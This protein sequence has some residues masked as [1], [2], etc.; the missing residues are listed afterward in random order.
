MLA[1]AAG[2]CEKAALAPIFEISDDDAADRIFIEGSEDDDVFVLQG[3]ASGEEAGATDIAVFY[4]RAYDVF[5]RN[6]RRDDGDTVTIEIGGI[7]KLV[8]PVVQGD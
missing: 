3:L 2:G 6:S 8:N 7:G 5:I 1:G 4:E